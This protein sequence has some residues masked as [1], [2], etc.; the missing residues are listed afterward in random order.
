L[1]RSLRSFLWRIPIEREVEEELGLH[2][3]MRRREGRP[4]DRDELEQVRR[5]CLA[6]ARHTE[7]QMRLTQWFE[8]RRTDVRF[9]LRQLR[10]SPGFTAVAALT[11]ALGIGANSAIFALADATF[12]R[13]L[14]YPYP[15]ER[16]VMIG[17]SRG[18]G[19][20]GTVAPL[21]FRDWSEQNQTFDVMGA[22]TGMPAAIV[23]PDGTPEQLPAQQVTPGFFEALGAR[24]IVGRTFQVSD[25]AA[26]RPVVLSE[27]LWRTQFGGDPAAVGRQM[28]IGGQPFTVIGV[29]PASFEFA[30]A[31]IGDGATES[32]QL[33]TIFAIT[34]QGFERVSHLLRVVGRLKPGITVERAQKDLD[35]VAARLAAQFP[36]TNKGHGVVLQPLRDALIGREL[37]LTSLLLLGVVGFVLLMC[38]ANVA[39]LLV[40]QASGRARELAVRAALGAGR[41]RV[42]AQLITESLVLASIGG[43]LAL[44]VAWALI[45]VAS[46][47]VP[48]GV[49]PVAVTVAF[50]ARVIAAC[51]VCALVVGVLFGVAPA[52]QSSRGR[53]ADAI[54]ADGRVTPR[55]SGWLR[56]SL[57]SAQVATAVLVL[58]GAGLFLRA[59]VTLEGLDSGPRASEVLTGI[60]NLPFP[61]PGTASQYPTAA[62]ALRFFDAVE[63]EVRG[64]PG[65][66][67]VAWG[68]P[69]PLDGTWFGSP[70][71][72]VGEPPKPVA[73]WD[74]ATYQ[75]VGP[76]YFA[77]LDL[78]IVA[79]RS[80]TLA[81]R[82]ESPAV[83][84]VSEAFAAR[85]LK[86]RNPVGTRLVLPRMNFGLPAAPP[87]E[88]QIVG[89]AR[90]ARVRAAETEP[91]PHVYVPL[92]Q[93]NWW[94][95]SLIVR[96]DHD[97]ALALLEP[98][99][100]AMAR[101][102][103]ERVFRL[104]RTMATIA[105]EATARPR[106]RAVLVAAF[107][108]LALTLA[109]VGVFGVLSQLVQ[110]R[111]REF[112]VRI[113]LGASRQNVIG[114]VVRHAARITTIGLVAGLA[115]AFALGRL[116]ATLIFP[117]AP[118]DP[119][120]YM[121]APLVAVV[122]AA[123]ACVVP[124]WRATRVD[125]AT[126][127][128]DE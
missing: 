19:T 111:M 102:D 63:N 5:S 127:F 99:R 96:P 70:F 44:G 52:W 49:L 94:V 51:A 68:G 48:A 7:R 72:I 125:P 9:A 42:V 53:L 11:L 14:P 103:R 35:V 45:A 128:R 4:L 36:A 61:A 81:D 117:I 84:I 39:S 28:A 64:I 106:F 98:V 78:P 47:I 65:V 2:A 38:C 40:A 13:Q 55:S 15:A 41:G 30:P 62:D 113:A 126:A 12:L 95:A 80:F 33:W 97:N 32:P 88:V 92:A 34:D 119:V 24:P 114:L 50:D 116:L 112:G 16:L 46:S 105:H 8:E 120:T 21:D 115:L 54:V 101:I 57:V 86:G 23:R 87:P 121:V 124:A 89:V 107:A 109:T 90:Q 118:T 82:K 43:L 25:G 73:S 1:K 122:T 93:N 74:T 91:R 26:G 85:F 75:P 123:V 79:G 110:Q 60:V 6:I 71:A 59:L 37:Q 56:S 77:A 104:P 3:E 100:A 27:R 83:C 10:R 29:M 66:R 76:E 67:H 58:C 31:A 69:L 18:P 22:T 17:E 20:F 108:F